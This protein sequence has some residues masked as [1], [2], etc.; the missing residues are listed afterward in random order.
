MAFGLLM[1]NRTHMDV[2]DSG[3]CTYNVWRAVSTQNITLE[4][5]AM[6]R[7]SWNKSLRTSVQA[8]FFSMKDGRNYVCVWGGGGQLPSH[9]EAS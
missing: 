9:E 2:S 7:D 6:C 3:M 5:R 8:V 1:Y 4:I